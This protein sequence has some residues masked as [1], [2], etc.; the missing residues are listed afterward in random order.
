M[1]VIGV[2]SILS[3]AAN[4][5]QG[6]NFTGEN[7]N[8]SSKT[9]NSTEYNYFVGTTPVNYEVIA[10][11]G[12]LPILQT[13]SQR[14]NWSDRLKELGKSLEIELSLNYIYPNG[15]VI[16]YGENSRGY[17]VIVFYKNLTIDR[18]LID[19]M[20]VL[21]EDKARK[22][23]IQD[24]P[25]EFGDGGFPTAVIDGRSEAE[26]KADE[27]YE[28]SGRDSRKP[29][30]I[31]TYGKLPELKTEEQKWNWSYKTQPAIIEGL[32]DKITLYFSPK[33]PV[34]GFGTDTEG[35]FEVMIN[36]SSTVEK[37]LLNEIYGIVDEEAK[38]RG[39]HEVPV[40][41]V[42][43][44]IVDPAILT[45]D[46]NKNTSPSDG[47]SDKS[48]PSFGLLGGLIALLCVWLFRREPNI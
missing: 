9:T 33:G 41:F 3:L 20:Y 38:K 7:G 35:Y 6:S 24:V 18:A 13:E 39:I 48:V 8:L 37:S 32:R 40:R 44:D 30:A 22:M 12:K 4:T 26:K 16:T 36:K 42:L 23:G 19:E 45:E 31:A 2:L 21:I 27:E 1:S 28:K 17:F 29:V 25:V 47:P 11:Y 43:G 34:V 14:Q 5:S 15:K 46:S 10:T